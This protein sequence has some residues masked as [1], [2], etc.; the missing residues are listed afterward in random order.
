MGFPGAWARRDAYR[1]EAAFIRRHWKRLVLLVPLFAVAVTPAVFVSDGAWRAF[2][3]GLAVGSSAWMIVLLILLG[4][5]TAMS[6]MGEFAEHWTAGELRDRGWRVF[7]GLPLVGLGDGDHVVVSAAGVYLVETKWWSRARRVRPKPQA[8]LLDAAAQATRAA[9]RIREVLLRG[10]VSLDVV[11]IVAWWSMEPGDAK[12]GEPVQIGRCH[13]MP[14]AG[15]RQWLRKRP[16]DETAES[17]A[18]DACSIIDDYAVARR[19]GEADA[20]DTSWST[21]LRAIGATVLSTI[22]GTVAGLAVLTIG[23]SQWMDAVLLGACMI[24][25]Y[26]FGRGRLSDGA[27]LG[28]AAGVAAAGALVALGTVLT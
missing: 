2:I 25:G 11:P 26:V 19:A 1:R 28:W 7:H 14:G 16:V 4:S 10:C 24:V 20:C 9:D 5:G 6:R 8:S 21:H 13:V 17:L 27:V 22:S 12:F 15:L 3:V 23:A 18:S